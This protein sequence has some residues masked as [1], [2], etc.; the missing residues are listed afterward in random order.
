M[1]HPSGTQLAEDEG[2]GFTKKSNVIT[3]SLRKRCF[4]IATC[5]GG[6]DALAGS[7]FLPKPATVLGK[8]Q[9]QALIDF[10]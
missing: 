8:R 6:I 5:S 1:V 4:S 9:I 2:H 3:C 10:S 7:G